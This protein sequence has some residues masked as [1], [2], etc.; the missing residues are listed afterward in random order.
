VLEG[1][2]TA[3]DRAVSSTPSELRAIVQAMDQVRLALGTGVKVC[4][5]AEAV[6]MAASRRGL[7]AARSL[8]AGEK[9]TKDDIVALRP[10]SSLAP[11]EVHQL[12]GSTLTRDVTEGEAFSRADM[13]VETTV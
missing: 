2:E 6:N 7:Y 11:S 12:I 9:L 5:R 8:R 4:Q 13:A 1:D 3:I 10:A